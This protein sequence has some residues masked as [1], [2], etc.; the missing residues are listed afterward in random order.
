MS[1]LPGIVNLKAYRGDSWFQVFRFGEGD[2][3]INLT[4]ASVAAAARSSREKAVV[5]LIS[6]IY[7]DPTQG[8]VKISLPPESV[9]Y[10]GYDYDLEVTMPDSTVTT[11]V[12][13]R[14]TVE[15]DIANELP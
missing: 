10:G 8:M 11:W 3:P 5:S 13:G 12:R 1:S 2:Q 7:L 4:G 14:L 6:E 9:P 15:R